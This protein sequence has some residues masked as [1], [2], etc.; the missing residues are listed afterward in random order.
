[1]GLRDRFNV[2]TQGPHEIMEVIGVGF[3]DVF[4]MKF[5][6]PWWKNL[7]VLYLFCCFDSIVLVPV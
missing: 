6:V 7:L 2:N 5:D 1:M 4:W 3:D